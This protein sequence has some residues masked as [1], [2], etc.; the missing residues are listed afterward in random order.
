M[1]SLRP[2]CLFVAVLL[3]SASA[4]AET[5]KVQDFRVTYRQQAGQPVAQEALRGMQRAI[6][7][8]STA[9]KP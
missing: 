6:E 4:F 3:I 2:P 9:T 8:Q 5:P 7:L 1:P